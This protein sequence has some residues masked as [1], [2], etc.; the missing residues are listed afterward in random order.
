VSRP[1]RELSWVADG[2]ALFERTVM[3]LDDLRGQSR[4]T[5]WTRGHVVTHLARNAE[6]LS[7]LLAWAR[8]GIETPMYPSVEARDADIQAGARRPQ[9]EQLDDLCRTGAAFA[10]SAQELS[11]KDWEATVRTRHGSVP[12]S[13]VPWARVRELWLH[14]VD[15]DAGAE[16]DQIPEDIATALVGDVADWMDTRVSTRIELQISGREPITFGPE[17]SI[18][19]S[20]AGPT[21]QLAGWLTGRCHG[22]LLIAPDGVPELPRWI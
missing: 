21:Q 7:R 14:L 1:D 15:L 3:E 18:P 10:V 22:E 13:W 12:A 5:G 4:L 6:G 16:I 9:P 17:G 11:A 8:T 20:V 2:Q 19:L